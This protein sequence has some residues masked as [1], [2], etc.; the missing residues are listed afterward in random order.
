MWLSG[1][2]VRVLAQYVRGPGFE[3]RGPCAFSSPV[4]FKYHRG[5]KSTWPMSLGRKK[6]MDWPGLEPRTSR[7][8]CGHSDH[9]ATEPHSRLMTISPCLIRFIPESARNHPWRD[10]TVSL[11]L[12]AQTL[13]HT[14]HQM[15]Q[16]RKKHMAQLELEPRTSHRPCEHSDHWATEPHGWPVTPGPFEQNFV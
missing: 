15:S 11:L 14:G 10:E 16:G 4:T 7:I 5:G 6:H 8:P 13:S 9:W 3:S 2:V 1:S 12:A